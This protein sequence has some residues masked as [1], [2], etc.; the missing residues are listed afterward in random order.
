MRKSIAICLVLS[1]LTTVNTIFAN[2][3]LTNLKF[4]IEHFE[5]YNNAKIDSIIKKDSVVEVIK[6]PLTKKKDY[7]KFFITA[8]YGLGYRTAGIEKGTPAIE[9]SFQKEL[10]SGNSL[11][12]KAGY[13]ANRANYYGL[14]F[15]QFSSSFSLN[16]LIFTEPN[17]DDGTGS[18]SQTNTINYFGLS[19]GWNAKGF[20]RL[21]TVVFDLSLGYIKYSEK[22]KFE[23]TYEATG[24]SLGISFDLS[25][26]FGITKNFKVGPTFSFSGGALKK[27]T[28][29]GPNGY[30]ETIKF[31]ENTFLSLYR[32][33]L[34][35]GTYFEF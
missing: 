21:D 2:S 8:N 3:F 29:E 18:I 10:G 6:K 26:Y 7:N 35:L 14:V 25:Y 34:M 28:V 22:I 11:L 33:D 19:S 17:G 16:N 20:T 1:L 15:S 9:R 27:Y 5:N 23:N 30:T 32:V 4:E 31:D 12:L 24:A 13:R